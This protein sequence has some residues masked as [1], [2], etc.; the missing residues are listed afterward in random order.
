MRRRGPR[1]VSVALD[2]LTAGLAP[3]TLLA[4]V[5]RAWPAAAGAMFAERS[6]PYSERDGEVGVRCA[7]AVL[8]QEL[9]LM[10][11]LVR[12]RLNEALGRPAVRRL[13]IRVGSPS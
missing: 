2:R 12:G 1:P 7:E 6:Q 3:P 11:E 13:R 9:D 8:A 5:Q 10:S 4:E